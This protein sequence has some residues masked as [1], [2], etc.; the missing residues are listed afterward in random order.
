[1][2]TYDKFYDKVKIL[3]GGNSFVHYISIPKKLIDGLEIKK[4]DQI[5]VLI[6]KQEETQEI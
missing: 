5:R 2:N 4:G 6:S 1:M 3:K